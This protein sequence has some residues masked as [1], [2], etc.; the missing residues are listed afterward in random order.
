MRTAFNKSYKDTIINISYEIIAYIFYTPTTE[1]DE[2]PIV[3]TKTAS[4]CDVPY[5]K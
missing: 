2:M 5:V 3:G 1:V 4:N